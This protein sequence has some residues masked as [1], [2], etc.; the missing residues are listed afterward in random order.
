MRIE[1]LVESFCSE[2]SRLLGPCTAL[3]RH[4][5]AKR[6]GLAARVAGAVLGLDIEFR[7]PAIVCTAQGPPKEDSLGQNLASNSRNAF[8]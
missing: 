4:A 3:E 1:E 8:L 5:R 6:L 2:A 7:L